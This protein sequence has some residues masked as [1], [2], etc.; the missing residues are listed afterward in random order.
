MFAA[1]EQGQAKQAKK[2]K[3]KN[4]GHE[5]FG[6][7]MWEEAEQAEEAKKLVSNPMLAAVGEQA[8]PVKAKKKSKQKNKGHEMFGNPMFAEDEEGED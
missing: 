5:M 1:A 8:E 2:S 7:P 3:Q 6:N 4:K